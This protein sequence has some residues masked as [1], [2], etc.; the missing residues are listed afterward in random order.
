MN[1]G[2]AWSFLVVK[3]EDGLKGNA[4]GVDA[5]ALGGGGLFVLF[6]VPLLLLLLLLVVVVVGGGCACASFGLGLGVGLGLGLGLG[7]LACGGRRRG[8]MVDDDGEFVLEVEEAGWER[9]IRDVAE[10][11]EVER[12]CVAAQR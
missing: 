1:A 10:I 7:G 12:V 8:A 6:R 3:G 5:F 11:G 4:G 2:K 9:Y